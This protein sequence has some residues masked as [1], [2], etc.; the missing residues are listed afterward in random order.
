MMRRSKELDE[1]IEKS[2]A[3]TMIRLIRCE[4]KNLGNVKKR[5]QVERFE[6]SS[7]NVTMLQGVI[8]T[9][10]ERDISIDSLWSSRDSLK[11]I[12]DW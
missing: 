7:I 12:A 9:S 1:S 8:R 2:R 10:F 6:W 5:E 11:T 4:I 3:K